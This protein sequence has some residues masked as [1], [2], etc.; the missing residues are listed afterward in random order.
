MRG[1]GGRRVQVARARLRQWTPRTEARFLAALA[2]CC[3]VRAACRV[4]GMTPPAAY[5][6]YNR[7]PDFEKRW[8]DAL[9]E[10]YLRLEMALI[11]SAG[12]AFRPVDYPPDVPIEPMSVDQA[13]ILLHQH[14]ARVHKIGKPQGRAFRLP[15]TSEDVFESITHKLDRMEAKIRAEEMPGKPGARRGLDRGMK[16]VRGG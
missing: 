1:G 6:H 16:V 5:H 3:N 10:G 9:E 12:R 14:Q 7:W 15:R 11:E 2:A 4:V 13:M 8:N